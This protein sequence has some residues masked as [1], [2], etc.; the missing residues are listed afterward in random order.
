[1]S[2]VRN[3]KM[4]LKLL[5]HHEELFAAI[6]RRFIAAVDMCSLCALG[7]VSRRLRDA[8]L[9]LPWWRH[10]CKLSHCNSAIKTI[11]ILSNKFVTLRDFNNKLTTY[12]YYSLE[13]GNIYDDTYYIHCTNK[14]SYIMSHTVSG[15]KI[16]KGRINTF[17][18]INIIGDKPKW[19]NKYTSYIIYDVGISVGYT[20]KI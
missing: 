18:P 14:P 3:K 10:C 19:L 16:S 17:I 9:A 1:M 2:L 6:L 13:R 7:A 12:S 5:G 8:V 20:F 11:N 4:L 15:C